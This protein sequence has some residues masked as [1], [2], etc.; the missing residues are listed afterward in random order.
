MGP[1]FSNNLAISSALFETPRIIAL[2]ACWNKSKS[3]TVSFVAALNLSIAI[4]ALFV[5]PLKLLKALLCS[6]YKFIKKSVV[7]LLGLCVLEPRPP[8]ISPF[9]WL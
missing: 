9:R 4:V 8:L 5:P 6:M 7:T 3:E 2:F 1:D